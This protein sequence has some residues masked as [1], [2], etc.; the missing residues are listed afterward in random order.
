MQKETEMRI[1]ENVAMAAVAFTAN[2]LIIGSM[3]L[4]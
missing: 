2:A 4:S 3:L 1:I